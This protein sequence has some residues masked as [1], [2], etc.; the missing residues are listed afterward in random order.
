MADETIVAA[1][2]IDPD[3]QN[4]VALSKLLPMTWTGC[5]RPESTICGITANTVGV[6]T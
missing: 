6:L 1:V 4:N 2:R 5:W 3:V